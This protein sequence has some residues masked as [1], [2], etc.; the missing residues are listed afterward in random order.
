MNLRLASLRVVNA[1][2]GQVLSTSTTA[3][4]DHGPASCDTYRWLAAEFVDGARRRRNVCDK[5][6]QRYV[7][8]NRTAFNC[9]Q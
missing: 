6:S 5:K 1:A 9:T 8:D 7:K 3:P 2:T 4:P